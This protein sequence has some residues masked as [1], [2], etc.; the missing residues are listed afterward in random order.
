MSKPTRR[1]FLED[2][3]LATAAALSAAAIPAVAAEKDSGDPPGPN[4]KLGVAV[5]G[6]R[7]Q[8]STHCTAYV[9]NPATEILYICDPDAR[10]GENQAEAVGEKQGRRPKVVTDMR[11]AFDDAAVDVVSIAT[12][13]HWHALAGIWAMQASKDVYVEKPVSQFVSE[14]RSLV[15]AARRYRRICQT[16]T[17]IRSSPAVRNAIEYLHSGK[18]GDV[19]LARGLCYDRRD[20]IGPK[21]NYPVPAHIDYNLWC[22]PAPD[23]RLTRPRF[24]YDWHWQWAYGNGNLGNQGIHQMDVARWGLGANRLSQGVISYGGRF[25]YED[26][27]ETPNTSVTVHDYGHKSLVFEVRGLQSSPYRGAGV[28]VIFEGSDGYLVNP[29]NTSATAF[30]KDGTGI[31]TFNGGG[32]HFGNFIAA[33]L[34]RRIDQLNAEIL[35]G[36]LSSALC[37]L[38][39]ISY[40]LGRL[41]S[42]AEALERLDSIS[43]HQN[44]RET[45]ERTEEHLKANHLDVAKTQV[46]LG[47]WLK[48]DPDREAFV[49]SSPAD[50]YL[51]RNDRT[52]FEVPKPDQ[53]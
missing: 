48:F 5:L 52:G 20:S 10:V 37:H 26:A 31:K 18:L 14:G 13:N 23:G 43:F 33:V 28:G 32:D 9:K 22:G 41:A 24:H 15:A 7:G 40:R 19:T 35:E 38:S 21:G 36:H 25:G 51:A 53:V 1:Q 27:G 3:M 4:E 17:Q 12:P 44:A 45:F 16:G 8:G 46:R 42:P 29:D 49:D 34:A 39:N 6:V 11:R 47:P 2:S 30:G 50:M